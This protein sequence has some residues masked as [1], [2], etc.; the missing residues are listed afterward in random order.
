M[1]IFIL[2]FFTL[3]C[4]GSSSVN[5]NISSLT[6]LN[7]KY[8]IPGIGGLIYSNTKI[9]EISVTG[10]RKFGTEEALQQTDIFHLGSC[11]KSMTA[12]LAAILIEEGRFNWETTLGEL[13]DIELHPLYAAMKFETLLVHRA[14][15]PVE[16]PIKSQVRSLTP[17]SGRRLITEKMLLRIPLSSPDSKYLY[18]NYSYIIAAHIMEKVTGESWED[19]MRKYVF[20]PLNMSSCGFG[21]P[22]YVWGH[23]KKDGVI[24]P[25]QAD[26]PSSFAP[27]SSVHCSLSDW[28]KFVLLHLKGHR[29]ENNLLNSS[30]FQKLHATHPSGDSN[31]SYGGWMI[32]NRKWANGVTLSHAGSNTL[33]Y[34]KVWIA[35][36][37]NSFIMSTANIGGEE[38]FL[39]TD[40]FIQ[41]MISRYLP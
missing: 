38:A 39:A 36:K 22:L 17:L 15:L 8:G 1:R 9:Q 32:L 37:R 13:L 23:M 29:G 35:P 14:G 27:S 31:Y 4:S 20:G 40:A 7:D 3:A 12:T 2:L 28:S 19:L 16:D 33:N 18:S 21:M 34:A 6:S 30:S 41:E 25:I 24:V 5:R 11:T 10:L 26:N